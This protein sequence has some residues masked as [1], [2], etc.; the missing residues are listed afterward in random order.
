MPKNRFELDIP[1]NKQKKTISFIVMSKKPIWNIEG[2]YDHSMSSILAWIRQVI[3]FVALIV[4]AHHW[5]Q[6][7]DKKKSVFQ[8]K[9]LFLVAVVSLKRNIQFQ[10]VWTIVVLPNKQQVKCVEMW[11]ICDKL[12]YLL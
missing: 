5:N 10:L 3:W 7:Y 11:E 12:V 9:R 4:L 1:K 2:M 8:R 6:N